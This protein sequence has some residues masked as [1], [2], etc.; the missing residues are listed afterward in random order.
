MLRTNI[1]EAHS[2]APA[3]YPTHPIIQMRLDELV[4]NLA[5]GQNLGEDTGPARAWVQRAL[6][7][8]RMN[9]PATVFD[10]AWD[11]LYEAS[12]RSNAFGAHRAA[13]DDFLKAGEAR[14]LVH[15]Q[16][17]V[18][19]SNDPDEMAH[20]LELLR[21]VSKRALNADLLVPA[22]NLEAQLSQRLMSNA[23]HTVKGT[24]PM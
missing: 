3:V 10:G 6:T 20:A 21:A 11:K 9:A 4:F 19:G 12:G 13:V 1:S 8:V 5:S 23:L 15:A 17:V 18:E 22:R 2:A 16:R 24:S 14:R 7:D